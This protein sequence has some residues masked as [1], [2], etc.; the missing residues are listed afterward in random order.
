MK[1]LSPFELIKQG[2]T[3]LINEGKSFF[4]ND[5][6]TAGII[7][8]T[9]T[10]LPDAAK[11]MREGLFNRGYSDA[12]LKPYDPGF[13][14]E[15]G[16]VVAPEQT[17][18]KEKAKVASKVGSEMVTGLGG[19]GAKA[20]PYIFPGYQ[21]MIDQAVQT[22]TGGLLAD[23]IP[24]LE[25]YQQ[26]ESAKEAA[27]MRTFDIATNIFPV[28]STKNLAKTS[29]IIAAS[30][31]ANVI[32]K[33]LKGLG[34]ADDVI[35]AYTPSL[36]EA[37]D[38]KTVSKLINEAQIPEPLQQT[39]AELEF[40]KE[41][42]N[43]NYFKNISPKR[44]TKEGSLTELGD[45]TNKKMADRMQIDMAEARIN[46]P[47][48]FAE[49]LNEYRDKVKQLAIDEKQFKTDVAQYRTK[50]TIASRTSP[51]ATKEISQGER[52]ATSDL[53]KSIPDNVGSKPT[54]EALRAE[55]ENSYNESLR[56][57]ITNASGAKKAYTEAQHTY[58]EMIDLESF[59]TQ[60]REMDG[61]SSSFGL[62]KKTPNYKDIGNTGK[63]FKDIF[64][65]TEKVFGK[66]YPVIKA[67]VLDPLDAS[68]GKYMDFNDSYIKGLKEN[69]TD[70]YKITKGGKKDSLII[71]YG[72]NRISYDD[73]VKEVG[74]DGA[75][76]IIGA[77]KWFRST[78]N[79][80]IDKVNIA[81]KELYPNNPEKLVPYRKD[82]FRHYKEMKEGL[83]GLKNLFETPAGI[84]PNL[85]GLSSFTEPFSKFRSFAQKRLG[86]KTTESAIGGFLDYLPSAS[87]TVNIDKNIGNF[88]ALADQLARATSKNR[89][90]NNYIDF[91]RKYANDLSGKTSEVD[92]VV[93]DFIPGG[94][95]TLKVLDWI[96]RRI[97]S[98]VILANA[99]ASL[100]QALN[101]PNGIASAKLY[102]GKGFIDTVGG[103]FK[104]NVPM[105][106]STFLRERFVNPMSQFDT[107]LLQNTKKFV[108]WMTMSLDEVGTKFI[109][110]SHY[111]KAIAQ[112]IANPIKYADDTTR[113][114]VAG[115][116]I[117]EVP[118]IQKS[119]VFQLVA[120][121]Q[122]EVANLWSVMG[123][124]VK[125]KDFS[126]I[127]TLFVANYVI[128]KGIES[129]GGGGR[130]LD[131]IQAVIDAS[132]KFTNAQDKKEGAT[133]AAGRLAGEALSSLP[134]G[135]SL[136]RL[137]PEQGFGGKT[138][139]RKDLFG[140]KDPTRFGSGVL[141]ADSVQ[142]PLSKL[143]LP[144][145][146]VQVK[147]TLSGVNLLNKGGSFT[148]S[149]QKRFD[150]PDNLFDQ[151]KALLFGEYNTSGGK[152]YIKSN[153]E[154]TTVPKTED[155][156]RQEVKDKM[157]SG[158]LGSSAV[159]K[160][161]IV[162]ELKK[163]K[164]T[165]K[166]NRLSLPKEE[167]KT[168]L[169]RLLVE[170][171]ISTEDAANEIKAYSKQDKPSKEIERGWAGLTGDYARAF[172]T[173][174]ENAWKALVTPEKLGIVEGNL[175]EMQRFYGLNYKEKYGSDEKKKE[176]MLREGI[177]WKESEK[178]ILE[179]ITP[180]KAGGDTSDENLMIVNKPLHDFYTPIEVVVIKAVQSGQITR[181]EATAL[182]TKLKVDKTMSAEDVIN[183]IK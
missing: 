140:S 107:G 27:G 89:N 19:L 78:Y 119:K 11:K 2:V 42:L 18:F 30:K 36:V 160:E 48:V 72:E 148:E 87:Y 94:R 74:K 14:W 69:V 40:R 127:A 33:E 123:G 9:I 136:A 131:P 162:E 171:K 75:K 135:Q 12:E 38:P 100:S 183:A 110:N 159:A 84:D 61:F 71:K 137:Y 21:N 68:K 77:E 182:M 10:G 32:G 181:K 4:A 34:L 62:S 31:D 76:D 150:A 58:Q 65:N 63:S 13:K 165:E 88:R 177:S 178:Y 7:K 102:S 79:E 118:L 54:T 114:L 67:K 120:P 138:P 146:G 121:F 24:K 64:R 155:Q 37:S 163:I 66:D 83:G 17:T 113:G 86:F 149:G 22:K 153:F 35:E 98:N 49:K 142:D 47:T 174:P 152:K 105:S 29:K 85:V 51:V 144:Y 95:K 6:S 129:L 161:Y 82:Y 168:E 109:W 169:K 97:K 108:V 141:V 43:N 112:K 45:M 128:N 179:H 99:S 16:K 53:A 60:R 173:D 124:F 96:N 117:G 126:A 154:R 157:A 57:P 90:L 175:V 1:P 103:L 39:A 80:L 172:V 134:L 101:I 166:N 55:L 3:G 158:E 41:S 20:A 46:D 44:Y 92:R 115:R 111:E 28:G 59:P 139:S 130:T 104:K 122:L 176:L 8:N 147:K 156:L 15:K 164:E 73:V 151:S 180:V 106:E 25:K 116:G 145:G 167:F 93:A 52:L 50:P 91:L 170:K 23:I 133:L 143:L 132:E 81:L 26:P 70:K 125:K 56:R 5:N